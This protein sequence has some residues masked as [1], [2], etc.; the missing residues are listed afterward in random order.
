V[1]RPLRLGVRERLRA[2]GR[3]EIPLDRTSLD[4]AIDILRAAKVEAVAVCYFHA[5]RDASHERATAE[6]LARAL[7]DAYVSLSSSVLPQIKEFERVS[8]TIVNAY[9]GPVLSRYL[10]RLETRLGEAGYR[11]PTLIIQSH[12]GV[13]PI[14]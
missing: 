3:V 8:T 2:D 9:V 11:G 5:W 7:P 13:A 14:A 6:I 4:K 1:P 12:G 10:A